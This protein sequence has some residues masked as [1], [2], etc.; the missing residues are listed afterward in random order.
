[1]TSKANDTVGQMAITAAYLPIFSTKDRPS[2]S[3]YRMEVIW[4]YQIV[5]P[6]MRNLRIRCI[7]LHV[8]FDIMLGVLDLTLTALHSPPEHLRLTVK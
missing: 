4:H 7:H 6:H 5:F 2:L 8:D 3:S 1:M